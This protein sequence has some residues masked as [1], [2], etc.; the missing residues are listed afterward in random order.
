MLRKCFF[1]SVLVLISCSYM[2]DNNP[3]RFEGTRQVNAVRP[4][5][6]SEYRAFHIM[7]IKVYSIEG[8]I[9]RR[10]D[11]REAEN[12]SEYFRSRIIRELEGK[13]TFFSQPA[14]GLAHLKI[15]IS[16]I[17][18]TYASLQLRPGMLVPNYMRGGA[19]IEAHFVDSVTGEEI[20]S[21]KDTKQGTRVGML[22]GV[23]KWDGVKR[24]FEEWAAELGSAVDG[25]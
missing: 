11:G 12:L 19:T 18:S 6:L 15:G 3:S 25:Y 13:H 4:G 21:F 9:L 8:D 7:P 10:V 2:Q 23:G 17:S 1:S 22:S 14:K 24:A 16:D 20:L 5:V